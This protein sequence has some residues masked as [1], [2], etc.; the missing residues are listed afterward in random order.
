MRDSLYLVNFVSCSDN[1]SS[2]QKI[3]L[4]FCWNPPAEKFGV[5][6]RSS[7]IDFDHSSYFIGVFA[8]DFPFFGVF[9]FVRVR[10]SSTDF[11][12]VRIPSTL[13]G[14]PG[15][16]SSRTLSSL[17]FYYQQA[18]RK[19]GVK[20]RA[21][22]IDFDHSSYFI[23]VFAFDFP[24]FGVFEFVRVCRSST[25]FDTFPII[26]RILA[27]IP[28]VSVIKKFTRLHLSSNFTALIVRVSPD[29]AHNRPFIKA[30]NEPLPFA[31]L[32]KTMED[33]FGS[34]K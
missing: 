33:L 3:S 28:L 18:T 8:F 19:F 11:D 20:V 5:K 10:R 17:Q 12:Q 27:T 6:V 23:G 15:S 16:V 30:S 25:D 7:S 32:Q 34:E 29:S 31:R 21:S 4:Q 2:V 22:S 24:F 9:E 13:P 26:H 14:E 1:F